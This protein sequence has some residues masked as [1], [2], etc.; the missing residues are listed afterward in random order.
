MPCYIRYVLDSGVFILNLSFL[1]DR[2]QAGI[3]NILTYG[4]L[5]ASNQ[6]NT[7]LCYIFYITITHRSLFLKE[8]IVEVSPSLA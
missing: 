6:V 8:R 4:I 1:F 5:Q 3:R 2:Q 7:M